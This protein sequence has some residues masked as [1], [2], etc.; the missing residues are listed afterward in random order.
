MKYSIFSYLFTTMGAF[1]GAFILFLAVSIWVARNSKK[2]PKNVPVYQAVLLLGFFF[3]LGVMYLLAPSMEYWFPLLLGKEPYTVSGEIAEVRTLSGFPYYY[4]RKAEEFTSGSL[5]KMDDAYYFVISADTLQPGDPVTL[6]VCGEGITVLSWERGIDPV[7]L[8]PQEP[9][10]S[11]N[12]EKKSDH[13]LS[14]VTAGFFLIGAVF[15]VAQEFGRRRNRWQQL[16]DADD[17][18]PSHTLRLRPF[19]IF[20]RG[21]M[22]VYL[23]ASAAYLWYHGVIA[24]VILGIGGANFLV[25]AIS[26]AATSISYDQD[27]LTIRHFGRIIKIALS[28]VRFVERGNEG[29]YGKCIKISSASGKGITFTQFDYCGLDDLYRHLKRYVNQN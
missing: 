20:A 22:A 12:N 8:E 1:T 26:L 7:P 3:V 18:H 23:F 16:L 28:T 10:L 5:L 27:E 9:A 2:T 14:V 4:D 11:E 17:Y 21:G 6:T 29:Q 24:W 13:A 15:L 19:S 25:P